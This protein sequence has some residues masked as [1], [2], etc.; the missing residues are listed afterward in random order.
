MS[1]IIF[2]GTD[3]EMW[4]KMLNSLQLGLPRAPSL[5]ALHRDP[6]QT[7]AVVIVPEP[8]DARVSLR[9]Q[10]RAVL[11]QSPT[12][13]AVFLA[14]VV[15]GCIVV[16]NRLAKC[17]GKAALKVTGGRHRSVHRNIVGM[18]DGLAD[19]H[20][21]VRAWRCSD[22]RQRRLVGQG[23]LLVSALHR[24]LSGGSPSPGA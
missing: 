15:H 21:C 20:H 2:A 3:A 17:R 14:A 18:I 12:P 23:F 7:R 11:G 4:R 9:L 19:F 6:M 10:G 1:Q 24:S 8:I 16:I 22:G 5:L 13:H